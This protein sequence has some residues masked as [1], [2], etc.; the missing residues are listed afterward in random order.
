MS[1]RDILCTSTCT[2][3]WS[4]SKTLS[5]RSSLTFL[6]QFGTQA[7]VED[8]ATGD[9][10]TWA[11]ISKTLWQLRDH[12]WSEMIFVWG[13]SSRAMHF[14]RVGLGPRSPCTMYHDRHL[15]LLYSQLLAVFA[16]QFPA[17]IPG[18]LSKFSDVFSILSFLFFFASFFCFL[19][20]WGHGGL[21]DLTWTRFLGNTSTRW[22]L[23]RAS[24]VGSLA[25]LSTVQLLCN[26]SPCHFYVLYRHVE[27]AWHGL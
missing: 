4:W 13:G 20:S 27:S 17:S 22:V 15:V 23:G 25:A 7:F 2:R 26:C 16:S 18:C 5:L 24:D 10:T 21:P 3:T 8:A 1:V 6:G 11:T 9:W 14:Q 12:A 19:H